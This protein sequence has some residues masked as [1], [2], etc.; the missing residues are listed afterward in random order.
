MKK[1]RVPYPKGATIEEIYGKYLSRRRRNQ[2]A[3]A[4]RMGGIEA[5]IQAYSPR[6]AFAVAALHPSLE[7]FRKAI[8]S[9]V[10]AVTDIRPYY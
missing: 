5:V 7:K 1:N 3:M 2:I 4:I 6:Q 9:Q 10:R 8:L